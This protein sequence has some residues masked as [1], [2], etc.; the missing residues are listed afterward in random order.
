MRAFAPFVV[1]SPTGIVPQSYG[2]RLLAQSGQPTG[3][4]ARAVLRHTNIA[5]AVLT[6]LLLHRLLPAPLIAAAVAAH[7]RLLPGAPMK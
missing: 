2:Y 6:L 5:H 3:A 4:E 1:Y 7:W